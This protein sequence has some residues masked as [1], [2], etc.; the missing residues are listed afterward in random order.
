MSDLPQSPVADQP[1]NLTF[2]ICDSLWASIYLS[3]ALLVA[4][5]VVA[6]AWLL[7]MLFGSRSFSRYMEIDEA[8]I[9][10]G[11]QKIK[12]K[13]N[14]VDRQIA[15]Q[16]WVE[17]STRKIGLEI[18]PDHDVVSEVYDSWYSFFSVTRELIKGVPATKVT[19]K[20]TEQIIRLSIEV[21]N[22]GIRPHLTRW[23]ARFRR[24]YEMQLALEENAEAYPQDIQQKFS[25]FDD[26]IA[27]MLDVNKRLI[28]YRNQMY[29]LVTGKDSD[30]LQPARSS[31]DQPL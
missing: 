25:D 5:A 2:Y 24:W 10:I 3:P 30:P 4:L 11:D 12:L 20:D 6:I 7:W 15:Y 19:R 21:L 16:V 9:G 14:E 22:N 18:D 8:E 26:L 13:P 29:K 23:Q 28:H 27:D 17:L 1:P 31:T